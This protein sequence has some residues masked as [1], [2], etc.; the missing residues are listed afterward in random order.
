[1]TESEVKFWI[2]SAKKESYFTQDRDI[3]YVATEN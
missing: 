3:K 2:E 1:M